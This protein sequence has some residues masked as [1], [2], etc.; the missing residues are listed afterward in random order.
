MTF[1]FK[2]TLSKYHSSPSTL[3]TSCWKMMTNISF[4]KC[5]Q[6][7]SYPF[8]LVLPLL[9]LDQLSIYPF[10]SFVL[11]IH[12]HSVLS[13]GRCFDEDQVLFPFVG[14]A[15]SCLWSDQGVRAAVARGYEY[16]L[17]DSAL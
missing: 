15:L 1:E 9:L 14:H 7:V 12:A 13:C 4:I 3:Y 2:L 8:F 5:H 16:E 17:N 6:D 11:Q 10:I